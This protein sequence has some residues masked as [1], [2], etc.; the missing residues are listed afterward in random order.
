MTKNLILTKI[1]QKTKK[2]KEKTKFCN[3]Y[4]KAS[5]KNTIISLTKLNGNV[6]KQWSTKSLKVQSFRKNTPYNIQLITE[7]INEF[8]E[9]K[10]ITQLNIYYNGFSYLRSKVLY[11]LNTKKVNINHI[12]ERTPI[13]FNGCRK[14]KKKRR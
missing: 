4:I 3:L 9:K 7:Q 1:N 13:P 8:I 10:N 11:K 5:Y 12:F 6:V 14:K 2:K